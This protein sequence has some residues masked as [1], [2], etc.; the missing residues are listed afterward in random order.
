[1]LHASSN[2]DWVGDGFRQNPLFYY[3]T[4]LEDTVGAI[5]AIDGR[6][7]ESWLFLPSRPPFAKGGLQPEV[8]PGQEAATRLAIDHV[9]DWSE[10]Q[11]FLERQAAPATKLYYANDTR[12]F[13]ELPPTLSSPKSPNA[14]AWLQVILLK[15]PAFEP[16]EE[17]KRLDALLSIPAPEELVAL[18][19]AANSTVAAIMAGIH[20]I[21]PGVSQRTVEAAVESTCWNQG[22]HGSSFWPWALSGEAGVL[23]HP[24]LS[25]ARYDHLD[26]TMKSGDLVRLD[27]GCEWAHYQGD[28]GRTV[29]VSSHYTPDQRET[30]NIFVAAYHA[31]VGA[32]RAGVTVDEVFDAWRNELLKQRAAA[33]SPMAQRAIDSWSDR[34]NIPYWQIHETN[35]SFAEPSGP[36]KEGSTINFE[37]IASIDG[38]GFF[39]EDMFLIT[40]DGTQLLTPG[41]PYS[42]EEIEAAMR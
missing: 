9:V 15:Y 28:L 3:F 24:F 19:S 33:K 31:G 22:A 7:K 38:Q 36:L 20:A 17:R 40:K 10:L 32:I 16:R 4:G 25:L 26:Q 23:P 42:T 41:V 39:L 13:N 35:L 8:L 12:A 34:K 18:R 6:S 27:V 1:L 30:W 2:I 37:P 11:A 5:L 29:P 14:P 21:R